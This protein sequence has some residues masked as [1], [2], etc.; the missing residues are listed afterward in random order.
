MSSD[1]WTLRL[2]I[3]GAS[4]HRRVFLTGYIAGFTPVWHTD[5]LGRGT[6]TVRFI[7]GTRILVRR[8]RQHHQAIDV[9]T[10]KIWAGNR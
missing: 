2:F 3:K 8:Q 6:P 10:G 5:P 9:I 4:A 1:I 7:R